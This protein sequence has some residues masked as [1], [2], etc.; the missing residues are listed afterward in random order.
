MSVCTILGRAPTQ[1]VPFPRR[2][3][4]GW[5]TCAVELLQVGAAAACGTC[6]TNPVMDF[7]GG[8]AG[9]GLARLQWGDGEPAAQACPQ[10]NLQD[11]VKL[12]F[13]S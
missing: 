3:S 7:C 1:Q 10:Q 4:L 13:F 12:C 5:V 8:P 11:T 2:P 6:P 9:P